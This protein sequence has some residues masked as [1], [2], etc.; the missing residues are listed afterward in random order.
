MS[1]R[2]AFERP[3]WMRRPDFRVAR[4]G[5]TKRADRDRPVR[6]ARGPAKILSNLQRQQW[7]PDPMVKSVRKSDNI[8]FPFFVVVSYHSRRTDP[9]CRR[10][11]NLEQLIDCSRR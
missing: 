7:G 1:M 10:F 9:P 8:K 5:A 4:C 2:H 6:M 11:S 3:A